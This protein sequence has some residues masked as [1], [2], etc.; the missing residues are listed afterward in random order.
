MDT[1]KVRSDASLLSYISGNS[2]FIFVN[3][4]HRVKARKVLIQEKFTM[5]PLPQKAKCMVCVGISKWNHFLISK[6]ANFLSC[7]AAPDTIYDKICAVD[8]ANEQFEIVFPK[9]NQ[10]E[11]EVK[12]FFETE[13]GEKTSSAASFNLYFNLAKPNNVLGSF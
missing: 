1:V 7:E 11:K 10:V 2:L 4:H 13:V 6:K 9:T 5:F 12:T 3:G 8:R